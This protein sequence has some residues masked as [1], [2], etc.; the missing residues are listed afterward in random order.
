MITREDRFVEVETAI[1][2]GRKEHNLTPEQEAK[3]LVQSDDLWEKMSPKER[4]NANKR[5][6]GLYPQIVHRLRET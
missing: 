1:A 5:C 2:N 3:L 4:K 6:V